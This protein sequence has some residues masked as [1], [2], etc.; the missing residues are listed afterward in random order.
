MTPK[1]EELDDKLESFLASLPTIEDEL[2]SWV[3]G[4]G[5]PD[6]LPLD[7]TLESLDRVESLFALVLDKVIPL[8]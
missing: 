7:F 5:R 6:L 2:L 4:L 8:P 3:G 1:N